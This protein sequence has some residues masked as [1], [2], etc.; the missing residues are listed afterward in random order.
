MFC[1]HTSSMV[2]MQHMFVDGIGIN[3]GSLI[4]TKEASQGTLK[5]LD[6]DR[7]GEVDLGKVGGG[8]DQSTLYKFFKERYKY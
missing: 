5:V 7:K 4:L 2:D 6:G 3:P 8:H 1:F